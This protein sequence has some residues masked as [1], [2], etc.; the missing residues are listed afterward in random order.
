MKD[1]PRRY[2]NIIMNVSDHISLHKSSHTCSENQGQG[3]L[4]EIGN[5]YWKK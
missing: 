5:K 1:D 4:Q 3:R 2:N